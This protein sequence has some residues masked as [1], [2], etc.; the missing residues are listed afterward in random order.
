MSCFNWMKKKAIPFFPLLFLVLLSLTGCWDRTEVNDIALIMAA[1]IDKG[2][3]EK[4]KL[5]VQIFIPKPTDGG[6]QEGM[7]S[8]SSNSQT[9]V[10]SAEGITLADAMS[11][12]Q[13]KLTRQIFWGQNEVLVIGED[14]AK[15]GISEHIDF[16]MRHSG[17]RVRADVF[18]AQGMANEVLQSTPD[19]ERDSAKQ[20]RE[21]VKTDIGVR[22]TVKDLSQML[23]GE[24]NAAVL[25]WVEN[26]PPESA[27]AKQEQGAPFI[28]GTAIFKD[29][30][31]VGQLDDIVT[32]G[33]LWPRNE[34]K[35]G[36]I[37]TSLKDEDGY[38]SL[39]IVRSQNHLIP[40]IKNEKWSMIVK[41]STDLDI[42]QNTTNLSSLNPAFLKEVQQKVIEEIENREKLALSEA[43][44]KLNADIFGFA[45]S[46]QRKYPDRW[47]TK[48]VKW[49]EQFQHVDV[50]FDTTVNIKRTGLV[51]EEASKR[52]DEK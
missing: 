6:Q 44:K 37:T 27:D 3:A 18:I 21:L 12:L 51:S 17:P 2:E 38:V 46:F 30:K 4:I 15:L 52:G 49:N 34:I 5:S 20:L 28:K 31:M 13:E 1:G 32:R 9:F 26:M 25:P 41:T 10:K 19:L 16:W 33:I 48:K 7:T 47:K 42:I 8:G 29:D 11:K 24:S 14:L 43:Q 39:N 50:S 35:S 40:H 23:S 36:V 45:E 22:V